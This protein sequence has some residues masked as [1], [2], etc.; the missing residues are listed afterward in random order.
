[1]P[2]TEIWL[3]GRF[4]DDF[5]SVREV[6]LDT[7]DERFYLAREDWIR[8]RAGLTGVPVFLSPGYEDRT[9]EIQG[10]NTKNSGNHSAEE[11]QMDA[12]GRRS[13]ISSWEGVAALGQASGC[14]RVHPRL[15]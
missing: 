2:T 4:V 3:G 12:D 13:G 14:I 9:G 15:T 8:R 5:V 1:M 11:P 10:Q 7:Y 6:N